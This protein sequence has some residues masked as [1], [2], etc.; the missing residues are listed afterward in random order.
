M[1]Y[2]WVV[3]GILLSSCGNYQESFND[4]NDVNRSAGFKTLSFEAM[5]ATVFEPKCY[6]CHSDA[7]GNKANVNL[8][9]LASVQ[10]AMKDIVADVQSDKMPK[11]GTAVS[12]QMKK[13]LVLWAQAGAP[14]VSNIPFPADGDTTLPPPPPAGFDTVSAKIFQPYCVRCHSFMADQNQVMKNIDKIQGAIASGQMP[15]NAKKPISDSLQKLLASWVSAGMPVGFQEVQQKLFVP[16][17]VRCHGGYA[18]YD[19]V[20]KDIDDIVKQ[21]DL[22]KMPKDDSPIPNELK[23]LLDSWVNQKLPN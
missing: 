19:R 14:E 5:T 23:A 7:H 12:P 20:A 13:A 8:E 21:L 10:A 18:T 17:C 22:G 15:K 11:D 1:R 3:L 6:Q 9:R 16:Y 4:L 2:S